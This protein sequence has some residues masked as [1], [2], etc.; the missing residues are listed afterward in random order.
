MIKP[1]V[2]KAE[3]MPNYMLGPR[4][5]VSSI[6]KPKMEDCLDL[7]EINLAG[8]YLSVE[9]ELLHSMI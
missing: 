5:G 2:A 9:L 7:R 1:K 8:G 4:L 6:K 3:L